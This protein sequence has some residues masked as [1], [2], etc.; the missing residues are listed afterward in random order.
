MNISPERL[1]PALT[2]Y[3]ESLPEMPKWIGLI[4]HEG[5]FVASRGEIVPVAGNQTLP[6]NAI[7]S[8]LSKLAKC[9]YQT[10]DALGFQNFSSSVHI[11]HSGTLFLVN[12]DDCFVLTVAYYG[13]GEGCCF[14]D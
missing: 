10:L 12:L 13:F 3:G 2:E 11:G 14:N 5:K 7:A 6:H 1:Q 9:N 8:Q 4:D